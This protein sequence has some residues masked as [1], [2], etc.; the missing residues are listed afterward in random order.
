MR[1]LSIS[2]D[3]DRGELPGCLGASRSCRLLDAGDVAGRELLQ[4]VDAEHE[5][6]GHEGDHD[7]DQG[8]KLPHRVRTLN[9]AGA[10]RGRPL[11]VPV[12]SGRDPATPR[13]AQ[14]SKPLPFL[15]GTEQASR[16]FS[17]LC[18]CVR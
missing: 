7:A 8:E 13:D 14:A 1:L 4:Q 11:G 10:P 6:A 9:G 17:T 2:S 5:Q 18:Y 15:S 3:R 16:T 12:G